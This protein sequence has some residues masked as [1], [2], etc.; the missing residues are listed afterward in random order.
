MKVLFL[1]FWGSVLL[2]GYTNNYLY[3]LVD[4]KSLID[5]TLKASQGKDELAIFRLKSDV[6][7]V[8]ISL[9]ME[10]NRLQKRIVVK[11]GKTP[12][13]EL[14]YQNKGNNF[15]KKIHQKDIINNLT[16]REIFQTE[17]VNFRKTAALFDAIYLI[18]TSD[19]QEDEYL[20]A[21]KVELLEPKSG[22]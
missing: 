11:A 13:F 6:N 12:L 2:S 15:I 20:T 10:N 4:K 22:L 18:N 7:A 21:K 17:E 19:N 14:M 9:Q 5:N 8:K 1:I 3:I 16:Y